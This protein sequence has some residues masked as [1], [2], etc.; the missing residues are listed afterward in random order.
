MSFGK[1]RWPVWAL[2]GVFTFCVLCFSW[3]RLD[4]VAQIAAGY[5]AKI[6]CSEIFLAGRNAE[7]VIDHEFAGI[8]PLMDYFGVRVEYDRAR[9][10]AAGPLR[11][12]R[13]VAIYR[14]GY[15]CTLVRKGGVAALPAPADIADA[16]PLTTIDND[17]LVTAIDDILISAFSDKNA[18]HRAVVVLQNG[19]L[20]AERYGEGFDK[21]TLLLSW[22][23]AKSITA[24]LIGAAVGDGLIDIDAPALVPAWRDDDPQTSITW[25]DLLQ[26][27]SGL[28]FSEDYGAPRSDVNRMLWASADMGSVAAAKPRIHEPGAHWSYS[29]GTSNLLSRALKLALEDQGT[30]YHQ[31]GRQTI[32]NPIGAAS[33]VMEPD[34]SGVFVGSSFVYATARDWARLGQLYLQDGVWD[35]ARI[36][37]DGWAAFVAGPA[38]ASD[39][40]Y[41]GHFWL[42]RDGGNGRKRILPGLP[43]EAYYMSGHEGQFVLIVPSAELIIVRLGQTRGQNPVSVVAPMVERIYAAAIAQ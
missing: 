13:S 3:I 5:K 39:G 8:D 16:Q 27:Q 35:G 7:Q 2:L 38:N 23:M 6:A 41:G 25:R 20:V 19:A 11:I 26:M 43:E 22:S 34:A 9:V 21:S 28:D 12:G 30:D 4:G 33:V 24:T 37:P 10:I 31:F 18:G 15:G 14:E 32:F 42:N 36:L 1:H 40:Q 29:S 17:A